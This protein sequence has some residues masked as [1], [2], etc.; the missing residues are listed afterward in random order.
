[1]AANSYAI[2]LWHRDTI[3]ADLLHFRIESGYKV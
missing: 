1:M 3:N 2:T